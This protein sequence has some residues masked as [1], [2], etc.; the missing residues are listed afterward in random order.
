MKKNL[1]IDV[2]KGAHT[3]VK[4]E[5]NLKKSIFTRTRIVCLC[6][7][8][9]VSL[10]IG[11]TLA[12][13]TFTSNQTPNRAG[14]ASAD[15]RIGERT[16]IEATEVTYDTDGSYSGGQNSKVVAV[17]AGTSE[18]QVEEN[19]TVS[20]VPQAESDSFIDTSGTVQDGGYA[21]FNQNWSGVQTDATTGCDFIETSI[22]RVWLAEGW[23]DNW[24]FNG[25]GTF[26]YKTTIKKG[27][28]TT[29]LMTG[30]T[31]QSGVKKDDYKSIKVVVIAQGVSK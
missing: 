31:L 22:L 5:H 19:V 15:V 12:Y 11:G 23:S 29:E 27:E 26:S 3:E 20:L 9:V 10:S 4:R 6:L 24:T 25:D 8:L 7:I 2:P 18:G 28:K 1:E 17:Y 21:N 14:V 30:V 16:S 13:L